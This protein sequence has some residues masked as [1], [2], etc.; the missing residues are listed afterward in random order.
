MLSNISSKHFSA[1]SLKNFIPKRVDFSSV[2]SVLPNQFTFNQSFKNDSKYIRFFSQSNSISKIETL[3]EKAD[4]GDREAQYELG[5]Y[6]LS[7]ENKKVPDNEKGVHYIK[8][9]AEGNHPTA[10]YMYSTFL[11]NGFHVEKDLD[12]SLKYLTY[13]ADHN[14]EIA[15]FELALE[16]YTGKRFPSDMSKALHYFCLS[17]EN[18]NVT[19]CET[20]GTFLTQGI[21]CKPDVEKATK[22]LEIG[23][24]LKSGLCKY[25]LSVIKSIDNKEESIS[26][27]KESA[28]LGF[29]IAQHEYSKYLLFQKKN[30]KEAEKYLRLAANQNDSQSCLELSNILKKSGNAIKKREAFLFLKKAADLDNESAMVMLG[31]LLCGDKDISYGVQVT[32]DVNLALK[33]LKRA[34]SQS[35]DPES[36]IEYATRL[37]D[38]LN[39]P[40]SSSTLDVDHVEKECIQFYDK[41]IKNAEQFHIMK[42]KYIIS[43]AYFLSSRGKNANAVRKLISQ[44][45][46][47]DPAISYALAVVGSKELKIMSLNFLKKAL[48]AMFPNSKNTEIEKLFDLNIDPTEYEQKFDLLKSNYKKDPS[49]I[50]SKLGIA[51]YTSIGAGGAKLDVNKALEMIKETANDG[52]LLAAKIYSAWMFENLDGGQK[53]LEKLTEAIEICKKAADEND[54]DSQYLYGKLMV[55]GSWFVEANVP[56]GIQYLEKAAPKN[57][58]AAFLLGSLYFNG[59]LVEPSL[60]KAEKF[61]EMAADLNHPQ[62]KQVLEKN[63]PA[64]SA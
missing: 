9:A 7:N 36:S 41:G 25:Q 37:G 47:N 63:F 10:C 39:L 59:D 2:C 26:L 42:P 22:Y 35:N 12:Q 5:S 55:N 27:L 1:I 21:G 49:D 14:L 53:D 64:P 38:F 4:L 30:E 29:P 54:A 62:A 34:A 44:A 11:K 52:S 20:V 19:S 51:F 18:G 46:L 8:L 6:Y 24:K 50:K 3:K 32:P 43:Y 40:N 48:I 16:Y 15:Q 17:A 56:E 57:S 58:N 23:S 28:D 13:A 45:H 31:K 33:Y 61:I 60:E